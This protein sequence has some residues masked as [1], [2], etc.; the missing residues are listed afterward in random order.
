MFFLLFQF[1]NPRRLIWP[2]ANS[3]PNVTI[4]ASS[5]KRFIP[6]YLYLISTLL[7]V[8]LSI[9]LVKGAFAK[10]VTDTIKDIQLPFQ[11]TL[12][13]SGD[14]RL[15]G[16]LFDPQS[17]GL[18]DL[19]KTGDRVSV[20]L[21]SDKP[22]RYGRKP[23]HLYLKDGRW[24]QGELVREGKAT[25]FPY[26]GETAFIRDLYLLET[27]QAHSAL[28]EAI[29]L[30]K[31]AIVEGRVIDVA[32]IKGTTYLNFGSNWRTDFTIKVSKK[33][34]KKFRAFGFDLPTL[35]ERE[36]RIRGWV[37]QQNGPMIAPE[38]PAQLE[39]IEK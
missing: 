23:A 6:S 36:V 8:G 11:V 15:A 3:S 16:L 19:I 29:P 4:M 28:S 27:A 30:D 20:R 18:T 37:F 33:A 5:V 25:P 17:T 24:L 7:F 14:I 9:V 38:H 22:D 39:V 35:K 31:F 13:K 10:S 34:Q 21:L 32:L 26:P 2:N 12:E 1:N